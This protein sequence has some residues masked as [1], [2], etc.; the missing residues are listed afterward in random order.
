MEKRTN[1]AKEL[2]MTE[3]QYVQ[4]LKI[5]VAVSMQPR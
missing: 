3:R 1:V 5:L 2:L 4:N